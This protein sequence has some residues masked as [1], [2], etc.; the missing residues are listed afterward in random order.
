MLLNS[1]QLVILILQMTQ[2]AQVK[3]NGKVIL[4]FFI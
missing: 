1:T 4:P 2:F 3:K